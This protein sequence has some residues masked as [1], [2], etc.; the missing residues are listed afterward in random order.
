MEQG[1]FR[2]T[3]DDALGHD[4]TFCLYESVSLPKDSSLQQAQRQVPALLGA[5]KAISNAKCH[6]L[7]CLSLAT[8]SGTVRRKGQKVSVR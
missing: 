5:L 2:C 3:G 6:L 4:R 7:S 1:S 8:P